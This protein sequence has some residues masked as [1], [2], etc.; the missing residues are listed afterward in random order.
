[1]ERSSQA[2]AALHVRM[3]EI[4]ADPA[5]VE[6]LAELGRELVAAQAAH[7][8]LEEQWLEAAEALE[9]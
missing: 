1:M 5:R 9:A 3:E 4:S 7:A 8:E 6:E 2:V